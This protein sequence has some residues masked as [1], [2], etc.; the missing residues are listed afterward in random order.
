MYILQNG[1]S[2]YVGAAIDLS[3]RIRQQYGELNGGGRSFLRDG[4]GKHVGVLCWVG[5]SVG[6]DIDL[7]PAQPRGPERGFLPVLA[8][9][10]M[11]LRIV[12]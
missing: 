7:G 8:E 1:K 12:F 11:S 3:H 9:Y 2:L 6:R 10:V 5:G 4:F